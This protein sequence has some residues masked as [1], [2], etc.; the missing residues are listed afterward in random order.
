MKKI[1]IPDP[2]SAEAESAIAAAGGDIL[3]AS[4]TKKDAM[5]RDIADC[6]VLVVSKK[7]DG[8]IIDDEVMAAGRNLKL[9]ARFGIGME[10]IDTAAAKARGI[11]VTNTAGSNANAVAEQA[12]FLMLGCAR[13]FRQVDRRFRA[14][15]FFEVRKTLSVEL[16]GS[17]LGIAGCGNI[18]RM[19]AKKAHHGFG[20]RVLGYDPQLNPEAKIPEIEYV[21]SLDALLEASD[22]V[23][24]HLPALPETNGLIN[25]AALAKMKPTAA[26]I[27]TSRGEVIVEEDLVEALKAGTLRAAGLEVFRAE[28]LPPDSALRALDNAILTPHN[29]AFT[30]RTMRETSRYVAESVVDF[31]EGRTPARLFHV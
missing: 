4:G 20:M 27:N 18:G 10:I 28:P 3:R 12:M 13:D 22:F 26:L 1:L 31:I 24:L 21:D 5:L 6:D 29:A 30:A 8:Y 14:G 15:E 11:L 7:P 23:S 9:I 25:K 19:V 2:L 16:Y 17:I